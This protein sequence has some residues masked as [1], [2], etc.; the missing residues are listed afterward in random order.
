[1]LKKEKYEITDG[2]LGFHITSQI[3]Y[4]YRRALIDNFWYADEFVNPQNMEKDIKQIND[5]TITEQEKKFVKGLL[6]F[7][8][9]GDVGIVDLSNNCIS[10]RIKCSSW[11]SFEN[12]KMANEDIHAETYSLLIDYYAPDEKTEMLSSKGKYEFIKKKME[13]CR[14]NT[15]YDAPLSK[16]IFTVIILELLYFSSSFCGI[17]WLRNNNKLAGLGATNEIIARDEGMHGKC[18]ID[19]YLT[20]EYKLSE[21]QIFELIQE[22]VNIEKEFVEFILPEPMAGMNSRLMAQYVEYMADDILYSLGYNK[23]FN[24]Q[25]PFGFMMDFGKERKTDFFQKKSA[26]YTFIVNEPFEFKEL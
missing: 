21:E 25:N 5:G 19:A 15:T 14:K 17:Y 9:V 18:Y 3:F 20:L 7:F 2:I 22:A 24:S 6:S 26:E 11:L 13:W 10:T 8:A 23:L 12:Q 1:M 4:K 16:V